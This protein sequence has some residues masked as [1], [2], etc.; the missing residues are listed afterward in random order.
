MAYGQIDPAR[1]NGDALTRWYL[2][3]PA[4]IEQEQR[5]A[6]AQKYDSFFGGL[7]EGGQAGEDADR[8]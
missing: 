7:R 2:R 1:L 8:R 4:D 6:A 3:S 5:A